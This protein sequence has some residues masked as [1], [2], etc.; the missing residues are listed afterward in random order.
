MAPTLGTNIRAWSRP[1]Y[2]RSV[3]RQGC[4]QAA[5]RSLQPLPCW[6]RQCRCLHRRCTAAQ[7]KGDQATCRVSGSRLGSERHRARSSTTAA[8]P[9]SRGRN[10][11]GGGSWGSESRHR[12]QSGRRRLSHR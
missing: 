12:R 3:N 2:R 10:L 7:A 5:N 9:E 6:Q 1:P 4:A 8:D 11:L